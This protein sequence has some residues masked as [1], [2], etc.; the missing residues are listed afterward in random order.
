MDILK[1]QQPNRVVM[2]N[3]TEFKGSFEF[4]PLEPGFGLTVGNAL[5]RVLLSSLEGYAIT[6][7][8]IEGVQ[9]EFSTIEGV[10]EDVTEI[11]LNL[12]QLRFKSKKDDTIIESIGINLSNQF[13]FTGE[14]IQKNTNDFEVLNPEHVICNMDS[15]VNLNLRITVQRGRGF[16]P[17]DEQKRLDDSMELGVI[18]TDAIY[19]P[20][21]NVRYKII[22]TRVEQKTDYE[23]LIIEIVADGSIYPKDALTQAA[24]ILIQHFVLFS[25]ESIGEKNELEVEKENTYDESHL[26]MRQLLN[27]KISD[28]DISVRALNCL[29]YGEVETLA[30]LVCCNRDDLMRF[31]NFGKK[32]LVELDELLK[33]HNLDFGM[34]LSKYN[35]DK[36]D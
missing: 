10:I 13:Q 14:D 31:R 28:M 26:Y 21:K 18:Y 15:G 12:K 8:K 34:D 7:L 3:T 35:L 20:I 2:Q 5:R 19:T 36:K 16:V 9:H 23:K 11:V 24:K 25:D 30:D 4:S 6:S 1:F 17:A 33:S 29:Q 22:N 32:S 27:R